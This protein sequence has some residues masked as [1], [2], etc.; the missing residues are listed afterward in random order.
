VTTLPTSLVHF[1]QELESSIRRD[2]TRQR[3]RLV[4]RSGITIAAAAAVALG[5]LGALPRT[6]PSV[7]DRAAAALRAADGTIL[8]TVLVGTLAGQNGS[9]D[10]RIETWQ[11][12]SPPHDQLQIITAGGRHFEVAMVDGVGQLYDPQTNTIYTSPSQSTNARPVDKA[13]AAK[14]KTG[15]AN[16]GVSGKE[17]GTIVAAVTAIARRSSACSSPARCTRPAGRWSTVATRSD[18]SRTTGLS[19]C[20]STP[21]AASRSNGASART[22]EPR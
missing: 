12:S 3:R 9:K 6:G 19:R 14:W 4:R 10:L 21:T 22:D 16:T 7:V 13:Q 15:A 5:A 20:S 11:A 2:R 8:H 17:K 18:S 1:Q